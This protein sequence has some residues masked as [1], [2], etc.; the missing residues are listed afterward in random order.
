M[1]CGCD[2]PLWPDDGGSCCEYYDD[3][4]N[5]VVD[6]KLMSNNNKIFCQMAKFLRRSA[7]PQSTHTIRTKRHAENQSE[8]Q[9]NKNYL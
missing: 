5:D 7:A 2:K 8:P 6:E 3:A 9:R 1:D 4:D